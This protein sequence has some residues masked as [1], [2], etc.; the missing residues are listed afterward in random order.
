[1]CSMAENLILCQTLQREKISE[2]P[3]GRD[4]DTWEKN[5]GNFFSYLVT[6]SP[7]LEESEAK[8]A[9]SKDWNAP[10]FGRK[11]LHYYVQKLYIGIISAGSNHYSVHTFFMLHTSIL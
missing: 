8:N 2:D 7:R 5:E 1:M 4:R 11:H 3:S 10:I 6:I 9:R